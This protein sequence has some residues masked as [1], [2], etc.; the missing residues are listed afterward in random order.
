V[1]LKPH[2]HC[3]LHVDAFC[4]HAHGRKAKYVAV[5]PRAA[6]YVAVSHRTSTRT[7]QMLKLYAADYTGVCTASSWKPRSL[8]VAWMDGRSPGLVGWMELCFNHHV[9]CCS[10]SLPYYS[11]VPP[12]P[13]LCLYMYR[14]EPCAATAAAFY[15]LLS[16]SPAQGSLL[17]MYRHSTGRGGRLFK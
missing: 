14:N 12:L 7:L 4:M 10:P 17:Y 16:L 13:V 15:M 1:V 3:I 11:Q 2:S 8:A 6:M 5:S 9:V